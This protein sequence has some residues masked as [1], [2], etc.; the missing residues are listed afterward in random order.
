MKEFYSS[1]SKKPLD[2]SINFV[3]QHVQIKREDFNI[4]Q[5]ARKSLFYNKEIPWQKKNTNLFDVAM[6]A[7]D[8]AEVYEIVGLFLWNNLTNEFDKNS[9]GL[10]R[11]MDLPYLKISMVTVQIKYVKNFTNYLK[12]TDY[13]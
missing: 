12:K 6:R 8:G 3:R 13:L 4:I 11:T 5:H 10:Y 9:V 2:D 7:Y 1:I